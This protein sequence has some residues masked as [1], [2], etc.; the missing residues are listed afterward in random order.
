MKNIYNL[1]TEEGR[2]EAAK[3]I[4]T[5]VA[6]SA[7]LVGV[8]AIAGVVGA[9][10]VIMD[11]FRGVP[12]DGRQQTELARKLI[13]AAR[14]GDELE[15]EIA[16]GAVDGIMPLLGEYGEYKVTLPVDG[17]VK[18]TLKREDKD[19]RKLQTMLDSMTPTE[20]FIYDTMENRIKEL[21]NRVESLEDKI[22]DLETV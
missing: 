4:T 20:R 15:I 9:A 21:E 3:A 8:P 10:S 16:V 5:A 18:V 1:M 19:A 14:P 11:T 17:K 2:K 6:S 12:E 22:D 13:E 7:A